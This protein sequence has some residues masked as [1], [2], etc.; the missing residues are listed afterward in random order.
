MLMELWF[1]GDPEDAGRSA[2]SNP[3][4]H[5]RCRTSGRT[6]D[7]LP[8]LDYFLERSVSAKKSANIGANA[9]GGG[10]VDRKSV[11]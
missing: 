2:V 10:H 11:V 7:N 8:L 6:A 9:G 5:F 4:G 1:Q 3:Y